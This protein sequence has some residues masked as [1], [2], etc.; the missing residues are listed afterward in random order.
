MKEIIPTFLNE[1]MMRLET[2]PVDWCGILRQEWRHD[3]LHEMD[4]FLTMER[5]LGKRIYPESFDVFRALSHCS[6]TRTKVVIIGQDPYHQ[7]GQADGMAFSVPSDQVTPP[8][9][10]NIFKELKRDMKLPGDIKVDFNPN[11]MS[12][13]FQG[14]LLLNTVMTVEEGRPGSHKDKGWEIFTT[15][16]IKALQYKSNPVVFL[17][18]GKD[19]QKKKALIDG[20]KHFIIESPHPS[21]LSA[22][23]GF[24]FSKPFSRC[25]E[26][27]VMSKQSPIDWGTVDLEA[28]RKEWAR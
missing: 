24:F 23:T 15:Q 25:N 17:L 26:F 10:R 27:L 28:V 2:P 22:H 8:T 18:W 12:W 19:A 5:A 21:P 4:Q 6:Y 9:L 14:V 7:Y 1:A 20:S 16:I 13:L 11:L 3:Y